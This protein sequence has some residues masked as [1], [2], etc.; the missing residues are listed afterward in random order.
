MKISVMAAAMLLTATLGATAKELK[1]GDKAPP[2]SI[3][4]WIKGNPVDPTKGGAEPV[5]VV[6]FWA[7]WCG[8]CRQ[9]IPHL[10][11]VQKHFDKKV[12]IVGISNE[13]PAVIKSFLRTWDKKMQYTVAVDKE[14]KTSEAYM[15]A[16]GVNGIPHSFI[17]KDGKVAWH[18]HPMEM[19]EQLVKLTG[20]KEFAAA[21]EKT[22]AKT[23]KRQEMAMK[24]GMAMK[25]EKWDDAIKI[26]DD[27][28]AADAQDYE[29]MA[30]K[31][32]L[33]LVRKKDAKAAAEYGA[34]MV[35]T[36][37]DADLL[38]AVAYS[39]LMEDEFQPV[40]DPKMALAMSEKAAKLSPKDPGVMATLARAKFENGNSDEAVK[41]AEE[42]LQ[43]CEDDRL[44][45]EL[46][47]SIE[48]FRGAKGGAA[49][50]AAKGGK[51]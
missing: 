46:Q 21:M 18:G 32:Y 33:L 47:K 2:L 10:S 12:T 14:N 11:E 51:G 36:V 29:A 4:Q 48:K 19:D 39:I 7:T 31:Y 26:I 45:E 9:S 43:I 50:A 37:E 35:Q 28:I 40:K 30:Q 38:D 13:S 44:K 24:A 49:G 23:R 25:E 20:D 16:A 5:Y 42:A 34:K 1:I 41:I 22:Q 15:E 8:P 17:V 6:E 3:E 27:M